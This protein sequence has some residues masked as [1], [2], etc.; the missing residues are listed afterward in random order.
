M[1][2]IYEC[3]NFSRSMIEQGIIKRAIVV[4][5]EN[6]KPLVDETINILNV[7]ILIESQ[8]SLILQIFHYRRGAV[9]WSICSENN[10]YQQGPRLSQLLVPQIQAT[11][12]VRR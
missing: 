10:T 2:W 8:L 5:G 9:A 4:A 12:S 11:I 7:V 6:G 3:I 1:P